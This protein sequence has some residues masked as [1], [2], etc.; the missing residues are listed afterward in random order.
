MNQVAKKK[1]WLDEAVELAQVVAR[2]PPIAA[3]LAK[4]AVLAAD[5]TGARRR[6][7]PRAPAVRDRD[8]HRGPRR[9]HDR[10]HREAAAGLQGPVTE[11][12]A[13]DRRRRRRHHGRRDRP[14]RRAGR[15]SSTLAARPVPEALERGGSASAGLAKSAE[16]GRLSQED[17]DAAA[18]A[19]EPAPRWTT[20][21]LRAG[22][23]GRARAP[24]PQARA[25][26]AS[27]PRSAAGHGARHEHLV[28]P[29]HLARGRGRRPENVVGMHF[30]N[31][32]PLMR[33]L[34]VIAA[35]QTGEARRRV[36][37]ATG[38]AMGK[39]V[40]V[41]ADGPGLPGQPLRAPVRRRGAAAAPGAGRHARADRPHLPPG[42]RLPDG[43]VRADGPG[44]DRRRAEVAKSFDAPVVRRAALEAEPAPGAHG[45]R[46]PLGRK[47]GRGW[48]EYAG[49]GPH[50]P[51]DPPEPPPEDLAQE[52]G[53][54]LGASSPNW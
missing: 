30:F 2:R 8:G 16:R 45:R 25:V 10:V 41:A 24:R 34:E 32:P 9:G 37:R 42:R 43:P 44:R 54:V 15:A 36:A 20:C 38:E 3:R 47:T 4:Q 1:E 33:L 14:A 11:L 18:R 35:E 39:R 49:D 31:P 5:E 46:G 53:P 12:S 52:P 13:A 19:L 50:R 27:S 22:D 48:Y 21:R 28:D 17:A 40:I 26:R 29:R 51:D 6:A 23:R 7:R